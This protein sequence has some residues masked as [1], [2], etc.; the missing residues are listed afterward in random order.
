[1]TEQETPEHP[2]VEIQFRGRQMYVRMPSPEQFLVWQRTV[3]KLQNLET[4]NWNATQ[5]MDALERG[6][7][8][9]DSVIVNHTD[10]EWIDDQML[11]GTLGFP[12]TAQI[13]QL[14]TVAFQEASEQDG[15][16]EQRRAVKKVAPAKKAAR[17]K[18]AAAS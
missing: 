1:M 15:N 11:E 12:E 14:T 18:P 5:V 7:K 9:I 4:N 17:R 2:V 16:R 6:R 3:K 13:I 10:I 8:I